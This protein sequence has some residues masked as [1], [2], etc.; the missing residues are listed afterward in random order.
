V[1]PSPPCES[2]DAPESVD[3]S[4]SLGVRSGG[5]TR[6]GIGPTLVKTQSQPRGAPSQSFVFAR[7]RVS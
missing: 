7:K 1:P 3:A 4:E 2:V 5:L 6:D